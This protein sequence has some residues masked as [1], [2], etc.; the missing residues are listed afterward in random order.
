MEE[1]IRQAQ[2]KQDKEV[3]ERLKRKE[4]ELRNFITAKNDLDR[5][6]KEREIDIIRRRQDFLTAIDEMK[7]HNEMKKKLE[8]TSKDEYHYDYFP[9]THGEEYENK[10]KQLLDQHRDML[11]KN[12]I[13]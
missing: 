12:K 1:Q 4:E 2:E 10:K 3:A 5:T 11:A 9:F 6:Y 13:M 7:I 8:K